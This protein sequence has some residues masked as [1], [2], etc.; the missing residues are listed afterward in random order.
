MAIDADQLKEELQV[1]MKRNRMS[2]REL[3]VH[4]EVKLEALK[5]VLYG[6]HPSPWSTREKALILILG[7]MQN[8]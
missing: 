8:D 1:Y 4:L 6:K 2:T 5:A 7:G 3:A